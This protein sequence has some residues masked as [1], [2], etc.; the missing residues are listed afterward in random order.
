MFCYH[1][2]CS[3]LAIW[4]ISMPSAATYSAVVPGLTGVVACP[5]CLRVFTKDDFKAGHLTRGHT[6]PRALGNDIH[7]LICWRCNNAASHNDQHLRRYANARWGLPTKPNERVRVDAFGKRY[8][9]TIASEWNE[10]LN[11]EERTLQIAPD[12]NARPGHPRVMDLAHSIEAELRSR[13]EAGLPHSIHD[14]LSVDWHVDMQRAQAAGLTAAYLDAF[15]HLGNAFILN[16]N[17][18]EVREQIRNPVRPL[19]AD[20]ASIGCMT[21]HRTVFVATR[22]TELR[23]VG[24]SYHDLSVILPIAADRG[25]SIYRALREMR[26]GLRDVDRWPPC[27]EIVRVPRRSYPHGRYAIGLAPGEI[28]LSQPDLVTIRRL[29]PNADETIP[30]LRDAPDWARAS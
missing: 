28:P 19:V 4:H 2:P 20:I 17:L 24:V 18:D 1:P 3:R 30:C 14:V 8:L 5:I 10:S 15:M 9:G 11:R 25:A 13:R 21:E 12:P 7:T 29:D 23:C 16:R 6:L 22:P 26:D 27:D